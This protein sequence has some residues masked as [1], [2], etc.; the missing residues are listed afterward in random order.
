MISSRELRNETVLFGFEVIEVKLATPRGSVVGLLI[1]KEYHQPPKKEERR[2]N[3]RMGDNG[4]STYPSNKSDNS[5][6]RE[7]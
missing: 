3:M 2:G 6:S 1:E 5:A 4:T 7:L